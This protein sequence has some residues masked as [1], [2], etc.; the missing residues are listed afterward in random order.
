MRI[1]WDEVLRIARDEAL[2]LAILLLVVTMG[3]FNPESGVVL[4]MVIAILTA[5]YSI[6]S[7]ISNTSSTVT[8]GSQRRSFHLPCSVSLRRPIVVSWASR[9]F[10]HYEYSSFPT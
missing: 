3:F 8:S 9:F 2:I 6:Y 1:A 10:W 7:S 4:L 5:V